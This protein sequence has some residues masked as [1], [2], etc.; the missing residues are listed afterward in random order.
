MHDQVLYQKTAGIYEGVEDF[1]NF[2][3]LKVSVE[4]T[5]KKKKLNVNLF[6]M[7]IHFISTK[8]DKNELINL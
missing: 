7:E 2:I 3:G 1:V 4:H 8:I 5:I 6:T